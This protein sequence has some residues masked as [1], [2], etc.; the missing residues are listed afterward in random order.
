M[1]NRSIWSTAV[2][3]A[4]MH[5]FYG[6]IPSEARSDFG[7]HEP[8]QSLLVGFRTSLPLLIIVGPIAIL[9]IEQ[10]LSHGYQASWSAPM[11][12]ATADMMYGSVAAFA[13]TAAQRTLRG[14]EDV[15]RIAAGAVLVGLAIFMLYK[16]VSTK[17]LERTDES[18]PTATDAGALIDE[19]SAQ[20]AVA[21]PAASHPARLA[22]KFL[23]LVAVNPLTILA[24][25]SL[26]VSAGKW[27]SPMWVLGVGIASFLVHNG[28]VMIGHALGHAL[29]AKAL[30]AARVGG[31]ALVLYIGVSN[32]MR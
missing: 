19:Q 6:D 9:L 14:S 7:H 29:P 16:L 27:L 5:E 24:F 31:C 30:D 13:G 21:H 23:G 32:L 26:A 3:S 8:M 12:V 1:I 25:V 11:A 17:R 22:R 4:V 10:G 2:A 18:S 28:W 20:T 15:L